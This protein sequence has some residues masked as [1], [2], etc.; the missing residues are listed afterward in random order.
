MKFILQAQA[1]ESL[2][3]WQK[4]IKSVSWHISSGDFFYPWINRSF[5][6]TKRTETG[7]SFTSCQ[8]ILLSFFRKLFFSSLKDTQLLDSHLFLLYLDSTN[9]NSNIPRTQKDSK[10][11][12]FLLLLSSY[13]WYTALK[14]PHA[15]SCCQIAFV[16]L[17]KVTFS[18][19]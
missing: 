17:F 11:S 15:V 9:Q 2:A 4:E 19:S 5:G 10:S 12:K 7:V 13:T 6:S 8:S 1:V 18:V 16:L 3:H 14:N